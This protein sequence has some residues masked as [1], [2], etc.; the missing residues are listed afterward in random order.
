MAKTLL[1]Q[2]EWLLNCELVRR[3]RFTLDVPFQAA[4]ACAFV[5]LWKNDVIVRRRRLLM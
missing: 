3:V 1:A 2:L 4:V 5:K